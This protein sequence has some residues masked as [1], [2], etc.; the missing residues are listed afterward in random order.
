MS[1]I[2]IIRKSQFKKQHFRMISVITVIKKIMLIIIII[3][4]SQFKKQHFHKI[5]VITVIKNHVNHNNHT[6]ITVQK[7]AKMNHINL[8]APKERYICSHRKIITGKPRR[9]DISATKMPPLQGYKYNK[10]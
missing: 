8:K 9:G 5:S 7:A 4:K 1:V 10:P 3:R 2:I 6:E